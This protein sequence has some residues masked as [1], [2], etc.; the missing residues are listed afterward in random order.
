MRIF[1]SRDL[2][3]LLLH[4]LVCVQADIPQQQLDAQADF[5]LQV[6]HAVQESI[7]A[8]QAA[9]EDDNSDTPN[10]KPTKISSIAAETKDECPNGWINDVALGCFYFNFKAEKVI[11]AELCQLNL[12]LS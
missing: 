5:Q 7:I 10:N 6:R 1:T 11:L 9:L 3:V 2:L 12:M 4:I 8:N